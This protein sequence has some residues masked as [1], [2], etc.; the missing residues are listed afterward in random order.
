MTG[1]VL[2]SFKTNKPMSLHLKGLLLIFL[3]MLLLFQLIEGFQSRN[4]FNEL[5][6]LKM[7]LANGRANAI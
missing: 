2:D 4:T 7:A 6:N 1:L 3:L 5:T